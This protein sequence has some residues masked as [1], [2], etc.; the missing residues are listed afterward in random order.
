VLAPGG[1]VALTTWEALDRGDERVLKLIRVVD[2]GSALEQAGF[3][4]VEVR[5][6]PEWR[7]TERALWEE[8]VRLDPGD[9]LALRSFHDEGVRVLPGFDLTRR[10]LA[11][12]SVG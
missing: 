5:D 9:D 4:D 12:A 1:R 11:T 7:S 2:T 8:A 6:R 10:V 3:V